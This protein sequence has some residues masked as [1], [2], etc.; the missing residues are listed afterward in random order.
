MKETMPEFI[1][2][3]NL[4]VTIFT[5]PLGQSADEWQELDQGPGRIPIPENCEIY[6][7]ARNIDDEE[8]FSLVK[9][10]I[11]IPHLT[12]LNLSE[13]RKIS[14]V[15]LSRLAPLT[16]LT[17][18]NLSSCSITGQGLSYLKAL[19]K[20]EILDISYCN[21]LTDE[22]LRVL[23]GMPRLTSIDI[24]GCVKTSHAG[25]RKIERR[26]LTIHR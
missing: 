8:L 5:R 15:G 9:V 18:L 25:V 22:A 14:D 26:G 3:T 20:L 13:N 23:K 6:L 1:L 7:R 4:A 21:R 24:Q 11:D 10:L 12:Y 17:R 19:K 16:T 2:E